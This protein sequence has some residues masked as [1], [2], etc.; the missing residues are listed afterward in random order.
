MRQPTRIKVEPGIYQRVNANGDRLGLEVLYK[1]ADGKTRRR[2]VAGGIQDARDA[3]AEART[4]RVRHEHEPN[5]PRVSFDTVADAFESSHVAGL[6]PASREAYRY[7]L[8]R[9]RAAFGTRRITNITKPDIRA[10]VAAE[11]AEGMKAN[12]TQ[13]R[14][15]VL[16][17]IYSFARDDLGSM[18]RLKP[19]ERP[20]PAD[21][22]R[23][24]R[25]LADAELVRVLDACGER[26]RLFFQ[27][28]AQTGAR[29]SEVLGLTIRRV[30]PDTIT[31]AEQLGRDGKLAPLK[32]R[33]S[34]RTV[35]ITRSLAAAL[36]LAAGSERV[37][38]LN[39]TAIARA[40]SA[41]LEAAQLAD[42]QPV[43]HDL[44][45]THV[46]GLIADG[47]DVVEIAARVGD[48]IET[49]LRVY[50]HEFDVKRRSER[51]RGA[52]EARYGGGMATDTPRSPA[53]TGD[54]RTAD[55]GDMR[56]F[57]HR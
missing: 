11:R 29:Q 13:A 51:R 10:F 16:G 25:I 33:Q 54:A 17:A 43:I 55:V 27:T 48:R 7:A 36:A 24:H 3:L 53:I 40:W 34:K 30:G 32:T 1:D 20:Q 49:V 35:E 28:L 19:S 9:L 22:A 6:R 12:T 31:F 23:E 8:V 15:N 46:S 5:D 44:R 56:E 4:R 45:H 41:A 26:T 39:H 37:F 42:P 47:W 52:L 57:R 14:L 38:D 50:S 2:A 18:P 21:D